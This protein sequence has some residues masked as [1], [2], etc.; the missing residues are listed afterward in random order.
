MPSAPPLRLFAAALALAA[1][2]A[3]FAHAQLALVL[4]LAALGSAWFVAAGIWAWIAGQAEPNF[5]LEGAVTPGRFGSPS[6]L[7]AGSL[8]VVALFALWPGLDLGLAGLLYS[9]KN[10][11][12]GR[13]P[14][15]EFGR[16]IG[17]MAPFLIL[18]L[19]LAAYGVKR[20]L[21]GDAPA[22]PSG[23]DVLFVGLSM[24]I[25]PGL[26]VNLGM[27]DNLHRPR[28]TQIVEFGGGREFRPYW[29]F[30]G[31]CPKNCSFPSGEAAEAF[32]M[33][34]PASLAPPPWRGPAIAGA[35]AFGAAVG[36]MRMAFGGHFL[37]DVLIAG[38]VMW[39]LLMAMR[40]LIYEG[41]WEA[42]AGFAA[43]LAQRK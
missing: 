30:D 8:A 38:L 6:A 37:S 28:P 20:W 5:A 33:L 32:W 19:V 10:S 18:A 29:R 17:Y 27:K 43:G 26:I 7:L 39:G 3:L 4:T 12:A 25:G 40:R 42:L 31:A 16:W 23:R 24:L 13:S 35:L 14:T 9:G 1:L 22:A 36:A 41:G 34:A 11:F 15:G 2:L 21:L